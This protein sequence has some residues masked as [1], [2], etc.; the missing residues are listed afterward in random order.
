MLISHS[1]L[2]PRRLAGRVMLASVLA[3]ATLAAKAQT[4]PEGG[5]SW[6]KGQALPTFAAARHLD[7]T[8][9]REISGDE[10][11]LLATLQGVVNRRE[12][13]IYLLHPSD[14]GAETWLKDG[15]GVG[16]TTHEKPWALL[17]KY[18]KE[19]KGLI[20]YDPAL[21]DTVNVATTLAGL[22]DGIVASPALL[23]RLMSAPFNFTVLDDLRDRFGSR[24][25][26]YRWQFETLWSQTTHRMLIGLSPTHGVEIDPGRQ[27][28]YK[29]LLQETRPI[30]DRSN[31]QVR[32]V[33]LTPFLG[34][35]DIY[36][37][38][39]DSRPQDGWG[40]AVGEVAIHADDEEV[41]RFVPGTPAE[42]PFLH[43]EGGSVV[44]EGSGA[45]RFA[46]NGRYFVYKGTPPMGTKRLA[47]TLD[48]W[49]QFKV[50]ATAQ[51]PPQTHRQE[52]Y[53]FLRDYAVANRAMTFWLDPNIPAERSLLERILA[54][55][56]PYT[57]YLGW[58]AQ[59]VAGEFG[60]TELVSRYGAYVLAADWFANMTV[61][62]GARGQNR[63][64]KAPPVPKLE[65]KAYV[66]FV[67]SEGD[68][69]QYNQHRMRRLWDDPARGR[70]PITWTTTPLLVDAAPTILGY[71][72]RTATP[73][74]ALIAGPSGA[75]YIYPT[76]WPDATFDVFA[77][78]TE[79]YMRRTGM[80]VVY[81]LNRVDGRDI[82]LSSSKA[83]AYSEI[84]A[85]KGLLLSWE[86]RTRASVLH[87]GLPQSTV[88]G[89]GN[90]AG[91]RQAI[92]QGISGWDK[93]SPLFLAIGVLAWTTTPTD[94]AAIAASLGPEVQV[95]RGD[96][97]FDL[98]RAAN[99]APS[100]G[101]EA[102]AGGK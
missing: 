32:T 33:D 83:R 81:V 66:T 43:D 58:F 19:V 90:A 94:L 101:A 46:D 38:I 63:P 56:E 22:K 85:P 41:F 12:P 72:Q 34:Q 61:F 36:V 71:F 54:R 60:G 65:N 10:K 102:G 2:A 9:I 18:R 73:N 51:V 88:Q 97:Y 70:V 20:V 44:I 84:V 14:E 59:D 15:L 23:D 92:Q 30:E 95:V 55:V 96:H 11:L 40:A 78:E 29:T 89:T 77:R 93:G 100:P 64:P 13:R 16:Y 26:A 74:D 99:A 8:D 49:N 98:M 48:I 3:L 24:L 37:R 91:V 69:L 35:G 75:G 7:V 42:T 4:V 27:S 28:P 39:E 25:E 62:S 82:P 52:P 31:R 68:N 47:I 21:P 1:Q 50:S 57:P 80:D 5:M 17:D 86:N 53:A 87:K 67:M 45:H 76:P 6:P 79:R